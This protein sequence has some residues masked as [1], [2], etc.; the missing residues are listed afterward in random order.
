MTASLKASSQAAQLAT[1]QRATQVPR[2]SI[3]WLLMVQTA[4]MIPHI[5]RLSWWMLVIWLLCAIW[6]LAMFRGEAAYPSFLLRTIVVVLGSVGIAVSFGSHGALDIAVAALIFAFSLKLIEVR[7]RRDLY[8]VFYLA[9]FVIAAS[10][11]Y[12]QSLALVIY[13]FCSC[14]LICAG[15]VATQQSTSDRHVLQS[16][17]VATKMI[18]QAI[19]LLLLFFFMFPRLGPI[20]SVA[21]SSLNSKTGMSDSMAPGDWAELSQSTELAFSV[22]FKGPKPETQLLYWRGMTY[23]NFDGRRWS[24]GSGSQ[25]IFESKGQLKAMLANAPFKVRGAPIEYEIT[26][27]PTGSNWLFMLP[28][29]DLSEQKKHQDLGVSM[30]LDFNFETQKPASGLSVWTVKSY[31]DYS[32]EPWMT[33]DRIEEL[34]RLP[35][36]FNPQSRDFAYQLWIASNDERDFARRIA[37][38]FSQ[39]EYYYTLKPDGLGRH[40]VDEFLFET[41]NGFCEHYSNAATVLF[42]SVGIPARVVAGYQGGEVNPVNGLVQVRQLHAHAWIEYWVRG[43]GWQRMDPTAAVAPER[44]SLGLRE[45][46]EANESEDLAFYN[47]VMLN[48]VRWIKLLRQR[49]DAVNYVW[50]RA[51]VNFDTGK[52]QKVLSNWFGDITQTKMSLVMLGAMSVC[53]GWVAFVTLRRRRSDTRTAETKLYD[54]FCVRLLKA[55]LSRQVGEAPQSFANRVAGLRPDLA[56]TVFAI[57]KLYQQ[58]AFQELAQKSLLIEL[59]KRVRAFSP[60]KSKHSIQN[61]TMRASVS[62]A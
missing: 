1:S 20:W 31:L 19:P 27:P 36:G 25:A 5:N 18:L 26:L 37:K 62:K 39:N 7:N 52:Q 57:T 3:L 23:E 41:R 54:Q 46:L 51:F 14:I 8:L 56:D 28:I 16:L 32:A 29:A 10:F 11:L 34:T 22:D 38:H 58:I 55:G 59:G 47:P 24:R 43:E 60:G 17:R 9:F 48:D 21:D 15:L 45:A 35:D 49:V 6:R 13:Q 30:L 44:V 12:S 50:Q 42:R 40:T 33:P 4:V 53:I 61:Q 2:T